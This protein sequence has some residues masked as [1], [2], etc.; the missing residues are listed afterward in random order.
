MNDKTE[1][2]INHYKAMRYSNSI[3]EKRQ[4]IICKWIEN[5]NKSGEDFF[6]RDLMCESDLIQNDFK[7]NKPTKTSI[8][9]SKLERQ[10]LNAYSTYARNKL[11]VDKRKS[12]DKLMKQLLPSK[13]YDQIWDLFLERQSIDYLDRNL[14]RISK[15]LLGS[16]LM[17]VIY[18]EFATR[19]KSKKSFGFGISLNRH[20]KQ[21][22][23]RKLK[24]HSS[25]SHST[26]LKMICKYCG[27][28]F[29]PVL[30]FPYLKS[31]YPPNFDINNDIH[32]CQS[33]L[34]SA[35][36]GIYKDDKSEEQKKDDLK[37]LSEILG[38]IPPQTYM[39]NPYFIRKIPKSKF[40]AVIKVL[41]EIYPYKQ[42]EW[43]SS[44]YNQKKCYSIKDKN[45]LNILLNYN[46]LKDNVWR[47]SR[48]TKCLAE[49]G[50]ECLSIAEKNID[51]WLFK[52]NIK[53]E[54]EPYYP[55]DDELNKSGRMRADW[56]AGTF[57]LEYFG[58]AGNEKYDLKTLK[59]QKLC[60]QNGLN[61]ISLY[62]FD[63]FDLNEKLSILK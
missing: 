33:C 9:L 10:Y 7:V 52:N 12:D 37:N 3:L 41:I 63:L 18:D 6:K 56:K 11:E 42:K 58:L 40:D 4:K 51:D 46:L 25:Q 27:R 23:K 48:G 34:N 47:L 1:Q 24:E 14:F 57:Y 45:W 30:I 16:E 54:K 5:D 15:K 19:K 22:L 26:P 2:L 44:E 35:F 61:L 20:I 38:F 31:F 36:L 29:Y 50:H 60:E 55:K 17:G 43:V 49:D 62:D 13:F 39:Q 28:E 21:F 32:F 53:H 59:K 8:V